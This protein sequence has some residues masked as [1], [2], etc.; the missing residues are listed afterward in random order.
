MESSD[1]TKTN[2]DIYYAPAGVNL[3]KN[4]LLG[5]LCLEVLRNIILA[6]FQLWLI[7][8]LSKTAPTQETIQTI[9]VLDVQIDMWVNSP[10]VLLYFLSIGLLITWTHK[11][12][13]FC[14]S[15]SVNSME[16]TPIMSIVWWFIPIANLFYVPKI[17]MELSQALT[18]KENWK[19][20]PSFKL[21]IPWWLSFIGLRIYTALVEIR[22]EELSKNPNP[23]GAISLLNF[24]T[25][26]NI[27]AIISIGLLIWVVVK[28]NAI[29]LE[30]AQNQIDKG[31]NYENTP[32]C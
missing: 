27:L 13:K 26:L 17:L 6:S 1:I 15:R 8:T 14:W 28:L 20:L 29:K 24:S 4:L 23:E 25:G 9:K 12:N 2:K 18:L 30:A 3:I 22:S 16:I 19:E 31:I 21:I 5:V 32:K 11:M 10:H 7:A